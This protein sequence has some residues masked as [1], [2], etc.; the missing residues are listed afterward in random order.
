MNT[1]SK[2]LGFCTRAI[3][4]G[5]EPDPGTG[6][7]MTPVFLTSTYVQSEPGKHKGYEYSRSGNPTRSALEANL[8]SIEGGNFALAF[9]SGLG[10]TNTVL[11]LLKSGDHV[12]SGD[13][14]YGGTYRLFRNVYEQFGVR[15][16]FVD[17]SDLDALRDAVTPETKLVWLESPTNPLLKITDLSAASEIAHSAGALCCIDNTFA[18]PFLQRPL[19]LGSDLVVHSTTKYLGGHS[20]VVGGAVVMNDPEIRARLA[21]FQNAVGATP[22]PLDCFLVLRGIKT[23][24]LRMR[25]HCANAARIA[26]YLA[27][28]SRVEKVYYPGLATHPGHKIARKQMSDFGGIVSLEVKGGLEAARKFVSAAEIFALAESLGG[29]ESL[30]EI[31]AVMTH[32]SIPAAERRKAGL[33]DGLV[34]LSVGIEDVEDL[35]A[36]LER[37]LELSGG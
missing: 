11:N 26:S 31:P 6:A 24:G 23:L 27:G 15:F 12:V 30:I 7:I 2:K 25:Q 20:D 28:H 29:V 33:A 10:A 19:E 1:P 35:V 13:D 3:H 5:L 34:R 14:V 9:S 18:S 32:A 36:D 17:T 22:G 8:A 4:G 21:F 16:T 37:A